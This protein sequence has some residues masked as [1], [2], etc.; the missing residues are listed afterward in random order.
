MTP[1]SNQKEI[2]AE[3]ASTITSYLEIGVQEGKSLQVVVKNAPYLK[4]LTLCD[5]WG[6]RS[7]GTGRGSHEHIETL[8]TQLGYHHAVKFLD[9]DSTQTLPGL[10]NP[11]VLDLEER[12]D[13]VHID[14]D[15][16][17][18]HCL[19]DLKNGWAC[20]ARFLVAHDASFDGVHRALFTFGKERAEEIA[21]TVVAFGG[22][23]TMTFRRDT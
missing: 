23:G 21:E 9:G 5:T 10:F 1:S 8:L 18:E 14:G 2:L 19:A 15:H 12:F 13:L 7:G 4:R 6:R 3:L 17:E 16:S 11:K 20:C 22:H